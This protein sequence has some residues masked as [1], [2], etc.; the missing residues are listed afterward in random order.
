MELNKKNSPLPH[1]EDEEEAKKVLRAEGRKLKYIA[2]KVWR[3]YLSSYKPKV[4]IRTRDGQ[5][6]IKL[7][8]VKLIGNNELGIE[9][10][11]ENDLAYHDSWLYKKGKST[12]NV[13]G[14]AIMLIS[15]GWY[16]QKLEAKLGRRIYRFTYFEGTG[17][18]NRVYREYMKVKDHRV[19]VDVS[20]S[21]RFTKK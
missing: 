11:W 17:Y 19:T 7:K 9:L 13:K 16:N 5:R 10:I 14:H 2:I 3:L 8:D 20:W 1:F 18:L 12:K 15:E 21:G 4:Y 6:S